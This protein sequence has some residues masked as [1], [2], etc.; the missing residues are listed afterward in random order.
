MFKLEGEV[1]TPGFYKYTSGMRVDDGITVS[2]GFTKDAD[3]NNVFIRYPNG[4]TKTYK[5]LF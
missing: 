4:R 3:V 1:N 2:G 5:G